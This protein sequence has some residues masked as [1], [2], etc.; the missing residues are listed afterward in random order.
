M[1]PSFASSSPD[2]QRAMGW[3][4]RAMHAANYN[5]GGTAIGGARR[6][7]VTVIATRCGGGSALLVSS[8]ASGGSPFYL[9]ARSTPP[10]LRCVS[11]KRQWWWDGGRDDG[12]K[13]LPPAFGQKRCRGC[14][15]RGRPWAGQRG[16]G[17]G[18]GGVVAITGIETGELEF[19]V[20]EVIQGR[21]EGAGQELPRQI[22]GEEARAGVYD[23]AAGHWRFPVVALNVLNIP[24]D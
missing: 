4:C 21:L 3:R 15:R 19:V 10:A 23:F 9:A 18:A 14:R 24:D 7:R 20:D 6:S 1:P 16:G 11:A 22:D 12:E 8:A 17:A 5:G 2:H 13:I